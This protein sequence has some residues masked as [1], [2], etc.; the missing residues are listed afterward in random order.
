M[1]VA[2]AEDYAG[3]VSQRV[4]AERH[5]LAADWLRRLHVL[6]TVDANDVFPSKQLLDHIPA[7]IGEIAAYLRAPAE[8]AIAANAI[9][10]DKA[11]ELGLLRYRQQASV[12]QLLREYEI[13]AEI[14]EAFVVEETERLGLRPSSGECFELLRRLT[15]SSR[16]LMRTT[17]DAF[18]S[19]YTTA[20]DDRNNRIRAFNQMASHE[21]RSPIGTLVFAAAALE[22]EDVRADANRVSK[23]GATVRANAHRLSWLVDNL[24][25][26]SRLTEPGDGP[27][28][29]LF[30]VASVAQEVARQLQDM[31]VA[32]HV[33]IDVAPGLP[34]VFGDPARLELA[35]LNLV[36]NGIKYS[37][38]EKS[39]SFVEIGPETDHSRVPDGMC[40]IRVRDNGLG[41]AEADRASIFDRFFRAHA[42]LDGALGITGSGLGLAIAAD[43]LRATGG[44]IDCESVL[45][46]GTCFVVTVPMT[47]PDTHA[48]NPVDSRQTDT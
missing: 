33:R 36:S 47:P 11:R 16:T 12:H 42:H 1:T 40:A 3:I 23:I 32:R 31:A 48:A 39:E 14:L 20:I 46:E 45:G 24:Q 5:T 27:N 37:D 44:S 35:L 2:T 21:L 13:L 26:V 8:E 29:Q 15:Q 30:D 17:I 7:L 41:I 10:V 28:E 4:A 25:R 19:E 6:L 22:R 38:P 18:V 9:V 43:C 34:H